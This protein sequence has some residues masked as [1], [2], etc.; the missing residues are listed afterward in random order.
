MA[1]SEPKNGSRAEKAFCLPLRCAIETIAGG[2][3]GIMAQ[4]LSMVRAREAEW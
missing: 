3:S 4:V 1:A 2:G